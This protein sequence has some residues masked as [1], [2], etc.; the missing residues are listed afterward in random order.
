MSG[1]IA[2]ITGAGVDNVVETSGR[3]EMAALAAEVWRRLGL[4]G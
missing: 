4:Q 1:A 2:G 3:P